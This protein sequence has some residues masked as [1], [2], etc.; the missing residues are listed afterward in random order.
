[1]PNGDRFN[2]AD[3]RRNSPMRNNQDLPIRREQSPMRQKR[4]RTPPERPPSPDSNMRQHVSPDRNMGNCRSNSP[5]RRLSGNER[6]NRPRREFSPLVTRYPSPPNDRR[7]EPK[8][9]R[10]PLSP[11]KIYTDNQEST[12][13]NGVFIDKVGIQKCCTRC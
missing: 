6:F 2:N 9:P 3:D 13:E 12:E 11:G 4:P 5:Q 10:T 7:P 1:M 8:R